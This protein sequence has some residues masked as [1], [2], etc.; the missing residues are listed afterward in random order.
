MPSRNLI[1]AITGTPGSGKSTFAKELEESIPN[2]KVIEINDIVEKERL[3][4]SIDKMGSK[5]VKIKELEKKVNEIAKE[6]SKS[7]IVILVG[8]LVAELALKQDITIVMRI[9]LKELVK[10]LESRKYQKEKVKENIISESTDYCGIKCRELGNETYEIET[11]EQ[12]KE[13]IDYIKGIISGKKTK[14]PNTEE[15]SKFKEL[16]DLIMEDNKYGL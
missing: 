6:Q 7:S 14:T 1:I 11:M 9:N 15:I 10:R 4:S 16:L 3:Y 12:R 5:I 13:M 2:S 8:H